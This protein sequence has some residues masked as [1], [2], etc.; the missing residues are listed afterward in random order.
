MRNGPRLP[1]SFWVA[2][3]AFWPLALAPAGG[4]QAQTEGKGR[5]EVVRITDPGF[6]SPAELSVAIN[7]VD[8]MNVVVVSLAGGPPG[9]P[10]ITN[11]AYASVDGGRSWTTVPHPNPQDRTQ[12]DDAVTFDERGRVFHSYISFEGIRVERPPRAWNGIFVTRSDDGGFTWGAPVPVVDH[13][14]TVKP[15]EDKPWLVTDDVSGSPY[16]GHLY[17]AWTRFDVYGSTNPNDSTQILFSRSLDAGESFS[18]PIRISDSGGNAVD[19]DDT[20]EGA[21]PAVGPGGEVYVAWAGPLGIVFDRSMDGGWTFGEDRVIA[22]NPGGW[23]LPLP[24]MPRHNGMPVTG[25][26]VSSGPDRGSVY[27]NWIDERAGDPDV[28]L[29]ASRDGGD[30]WSEPRRVNRDAMGNGRAQ[31]FTWMAVDPVD[32]SVNIVFLDR[33]GTDGAAQTV[34]LARSVD[35]GRSFEIH[36]V[37][38]EPF[39]CPD[40]VFYGDYLAV[41]AHGGMVVAGWPHCDEEGELALFAALFHFPSHDGTSAGRADAA[42]GGRSRDV[43]LPV[44]GR[45]GRP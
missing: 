25:V 32:G 31:L 17:L 7:P 33:G 45:G 26:D 44:G 6:P 42:E 20:V 34:T 4:L 1:S 29:V 28:W 21:V 5:H 18:V 15:F 39:T 24:G 9:G 43:M 41:D 23:D 22:D 37:D 12:G 30:T 16:R 8:P 14:N 36:G 35:G 38:Q 19:S 13:I 10:G 2:A 27:V 40:A 11:Y 3:L